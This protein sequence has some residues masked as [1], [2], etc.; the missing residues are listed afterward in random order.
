MQIVADLHLPEVSASIDSA[1]WSLQM[2]LLLGPKWLSGLWNWPCRDDVRAGCRFWLDGS[3]L[4]CA[5]VML[6]LVKTPTAGASFSPSMSAVW[7]GVLSSF[8]HDDN[9]MTAELVPADAR[10]MLL[11]WLVDM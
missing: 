3:G 8:C 10:V 6:L 4:I 9:V 5:P 11:L 1:A 2:I 7:S